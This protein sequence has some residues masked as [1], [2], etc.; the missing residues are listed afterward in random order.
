MSHAIGAVKFKND[1][2][3]MYYEYD[4]TSDVV[5]PKLHLNIEGVNEEWR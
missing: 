2:K 5:L 3:I 1:N 4:G